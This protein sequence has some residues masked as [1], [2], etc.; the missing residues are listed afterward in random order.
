M[1]DLLALALGVLFLIG[2]VCA[3]IYWNSLTKVYDLGR[4]DYALRKNRSVGYRGL[5]RVAYRRGRRS[6]ASTGNVKFKNRV[7]VSKL[8]F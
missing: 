1:S 5:A 3:M 4:E 2:W 6:A 8:T 7:R